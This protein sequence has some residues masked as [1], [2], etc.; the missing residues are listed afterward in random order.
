MV[1]LILEHKTGHGEKNLCLWMFHIVPLCTTLMKAKPWIIFE[2]VEKF[3]GDTVL[4][5]TFTCRKQYCQLSIIFDYE[6]E[7]CLILWYELDVF[8]AKLVIFVINEKNLFKVNWIF[9][10][11][12]L[13]L[14]LS[15]FKN[16]KT[17]LQTI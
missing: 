7:N 4:R 14:I 2:S 3:E 6:N 8:E 12:S 15:F 9:K 17:N 10:H 16:P 1:Y 11:P 5:V 13:C